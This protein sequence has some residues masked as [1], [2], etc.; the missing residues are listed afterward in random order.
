[1]GVKLYSGE[2]KKEHGRSKASIKS[3][4]ESKSESKSG[5]RNIE[6]SEKM[7]T[8]RSANIV[9]N[10]GMAQSHTKNHI[11]VQRMNK[12]L[13]EQVR[14]QDLEQDRARPKKS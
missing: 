10:K 1:M 14:E 11:R 2:H 6:G 4:S 8:E 7:N 13:I 3:K 12:P 5:T 9:R